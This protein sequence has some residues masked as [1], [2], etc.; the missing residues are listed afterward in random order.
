MTIYQ[1]FLNDECKIHFRFC[2]DKETKAVKWRD[3]TGP[4]KKRL[5]EKSIYQDCFHQIQEKTSYKSY[6]VTLLV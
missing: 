4:E 5:F 6:G 2:T 3:L 1:D